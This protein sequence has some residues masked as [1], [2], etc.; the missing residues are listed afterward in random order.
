MSKFLHLLALTVAFAL[1]LQADGHGG[2]DIVDTAVEAGSF[3]TL[4]A[5]VEAAGLTDALKAEGPLTVFAP[6]DEAF[7]KLPEGTVESL[8][9]AENIEQLRAILEYHVLPS[10][11]MAANV[12]DGLE[13]ESLNGGTLSF[14]VNESG[15]RV[16]SANIVATDVSASNGVIHVIDT[17]ILPAS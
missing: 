15:V 16:G 6:T 17:V 9:E 14:Q 12:S 3:K 1:P 5:A 13:A 4:V 10:Q 7:A 11:V 8:L 2:K